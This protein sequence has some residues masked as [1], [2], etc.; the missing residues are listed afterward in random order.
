M[1]EHVVQGQE[2][3]VESQKSAGL[4]PTLDPGLSTPRP[5]V[6]LSYIDLRN[7]APLQQAAVALRELAGQELRDRPK[8]MG[9]SPTLDP[10]L[11]TPRPAIISINTPATKAIE[12]QVTGIDHWLTYGERGKGIMD[13][14]AELRRLRPAAV[15]ILYNAN[16]P[17]AHLKLEWLATLIGGRRIYG[18]FEKGDRN[19][20]R[21]EREKANSETTKMV[22][23]PFFAMT[24][25]GLW[26]R[27]AAKTLLMLLRSGVAAAFAAVVGLV[28][29]LATLLTRP[30]ERLGA[31][32]AD[33]E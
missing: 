22:P 25:P 17:K 6:L 10:R 32:A 29:L 9:S 3:R 18:A 7:P 1:D 30:G 24:R 13:V 4:S 23:V 20:F 19:Y 14:V 31:P 2:S 21:R 28:L 8:S 11:S 33:R 5:L 27:V 26:F 15:C 12:T 16:R